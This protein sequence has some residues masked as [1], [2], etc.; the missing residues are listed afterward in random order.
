MRMMIPNSRVVVN[1]A[2]PSL[3]ST[4]P[5]A[6]SAPNLP[7]LM[8]APPSGLSAGVNQ[9]VFKAM[10]PRSW[11][12]FNSSIQDAQSLTRQTIHSAFDPKVHHPSYSG[13]SI[14][15]QGLRSISNQPVERGNHTSSEATDVALITSPLRPSHSFTSYGSTNYPGPG[16]SVPQQI[17]ITRRVEKIASNGN[18][19]DS[20]FYGKKVISSSHYPSKFTSSRSLPD[21]FSNPNHTRARKESIEC[22]RRMRERPARAEWQGNP[23]QSIGSNTDIK[24]FPLQQVK[25]NDLWKEDCVPV[26]QSKAAKGFQKCLDTIRQA[27]ESTPR[28]SYHYR[29]DYPSGV[30]PPNLDKVL[31]I[32]Y[33]SDE[34]N[35]V[36]MKP[37]SQDFVEPRIGPE[38]RSW[39]VP[40]VS[41]CEIFGGKPLKKIDYSSVRLVGTRVVSSRQKLGTTETIR[42]H[43]N[44][45]YGGR[46]AE[47]CAVKDNNT[48]NTR[49]LGVRNSAYNSKPVVGGRLHA[50]SDS[51]QFP[52]QQQ[53]S[54]P[55]GPVRAP[56]R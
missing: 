56:A 4:R 34:S 52:T 32:E 28:E 13:S 43:G 12:G 22:E 36:L 2:A 11:G 38:V 21:T 51:H 35:L 49:K 7:S 9:D 10:K 40:L 53:S 17:P 27:Y 54:R 16:A 29:Q 42:N 30:R 44:G 25:C 3:V 48:N 5:L 46:T 23:E 45:K 20:P 8:N 50:Y 14:R 26:D 1:N 55:T 15:N 37:L 33:V 6:T 24:G 39:S 31:N 19:A 47:G 18:H 41:R